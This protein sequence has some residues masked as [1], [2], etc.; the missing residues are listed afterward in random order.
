MS[1]EHTPVVIRLFPTHP[2]ELQKMFK[3]TGLCVMNTEIEAG[4]YM[5]KIRPSKVKHK[6]DLEKAFS[7]I[8]LVAEKHGFSIKLKEM[9]YDS[10]D[11][12]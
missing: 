8:Q 1:I 10:S 2:I 9:I 6:S 3:E 12:L 5:V 7:K 11:V 4:L